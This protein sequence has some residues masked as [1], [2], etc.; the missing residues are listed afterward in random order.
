MQKLSTGADSTLREWITLSQTMFG[1]DS[2]PVRF[3]EKK[4][5]ESPNGHDEEV[6][7][8]ERQL[9]AL[10]VDMHQKALGTNDGEA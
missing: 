1:P 7:A 9:L 5:A 2:E 6:I 8:D 3:L 10:L 4:A